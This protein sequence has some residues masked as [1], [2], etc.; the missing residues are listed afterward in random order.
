VA[1]ESPAEGMRTSLYLK[2]SG[3]ALAILTNLA[4][5]PNRLALR[6]DAKAMGFDPARATVLDGERLET[7]KP[8]EPLNDW[9]RRIDRGGRAVMPGGDES[10][11]EIRVSPLADGLRVKL[12]VPPRD[13]RLLDVAPE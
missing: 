11:R 1:Y 7:P 2:P 9:Y 6:F 8:D 3:R 4:D 10:L 5:E 12:L 13:F